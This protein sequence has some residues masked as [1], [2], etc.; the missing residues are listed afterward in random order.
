MRNMSSNQPVSAWSM[1]GRPCAAR[2]PGC[3]PEV[4][5]LLRVVVAVPEERPR[6]CGDVAGLPDR[7]PDHASGCAPTASGSARPSAHAR[8]APDRVR[9]AAPVGRR[10]P[11]RKHMLQRRPRIL[12]VRPRHG[13]IQLMNEW[14]AEVG[15][16]NAELL[17][18]RS[19]TA[20]LA[21]EY[22]P[23]DLGDGRISYSK[24]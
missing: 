3:W 4:I 6:R 14:I 21:S 16:E 22:R 5:G 15:A 8:D 19:R 11:W 1:V 2:G 18:T 12:A 9:A 7:A 23:M 24:R 20:V 17:A 10:G 13:V